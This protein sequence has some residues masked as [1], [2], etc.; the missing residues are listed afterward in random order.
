MSKKLVIVESPAK[1]KTLAKFLGPQF[2]VEASIGHVRDLPSSA[3]DIPKNLKNEAWARLGVN[4]DQSFDPLYIIPANKKAQIKKLKELVREASFVYLATDEDREG[5]SISWHLKEVLKPKVPFKRLVFHEVTKSAIETAL[6]ELRDIDENLVRAQEARRIVDRLYGYVVSPLLWKKVKP[7]LS[8]GRVQ[9]VA[10]RLIVE[11]ER[12]RIAF[13]SAGYADIEASFCSK[14]GGERFTAVMTSLGEQRLAIGKDFDPATGK[15]KEA[16]K[17]GAAPLLLGETNGAE[18]VKSLQ[19]KDGLVKSIQSKPYTERPQGPYTTSTLQQDSNHKLR[20]SARRTMD[21]AQRLYENG[22]ITYMRTDS[23]TLSAQALSAARGLIKERYGAAYLPADARSYKSKVKNAQEA[24]EAIRPAGHSFTEIAQ[25]RSALGNDVARLY[26]LI[27]KRTVASQMNDA[28]G[29]R[30]SVSIGVGPAVFSTGGKIVEFQGYQRVDNASPG[31]NA[32]PLPDRLPKITEGESLDTEGL[33]LRMHQTQPPARLTEASLVKELET[34]GIGR[35]STYASIIET[36]LKRSYVR[37]QSNA[38][39]PTFTAF[40]VIR[41]L[42]DYLSYLV[43]YNFSAEMEDDLDAISLGKLA[44][45]DYLGRFYHGNGQPGLKA[46]LEE[47]EAKIDARQVCGIP[48]GEKD[49]KVV[50]VRVGRYGPFLSWGEQRASLPEDLAPDEMGL[51]QALV[52]LEKAARG[53]RVLGEHPE[54]KKP[55]YAKVGRFGPYVQ[56]G[57]VEESKKGKAQKGKTKSAKSK[58][59]KPKMASLLAGMDPETV[60]LEVAVGLLSLPR[61]IGVHPTNNEEVFAT[62]GRYG[63]YV[64]AG[65]ETRSL[66]ADLSPLKVTLD[67][68]L[69]LLNKPKERGPGGVRKKREALKTLGKHPGNGEEVKILDGRFGPY[70]TDGSVNASLQRGTSI[71]E[72]TLDMA[73]E[74][75]REKEAAGPRKKKSK[76][77]AKKKKKAARR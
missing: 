54:E 42:E 17:S 8:A 32:A 58:T 16:K 3:A 76:R 68:A 13:H 19:G 63:P 6:N 11:R 1:A 75:L 22:F 73:V 49:G 45:V 39:I 62:N 24:H 60:S 40:A 4:V 55:I 9:S 50:E 53:P 14:K 23:T 65:K 52:L 38:L 30:V 48:L 7:R 18:L 5:E 28:K 35:P 59:Q 25:V 56:L 66:T 67:E 29:Q 47:V 31:G 27:W 64:Y 61:K 70:V 51:E 26:E 15:L 44:S 77:K 10:V 20:Y 46:K 43:D 41:L 37:K 71:E 33:E 12:A 72:V 57:D 21:L 69:A 2:R 74:M 34:R 36:I